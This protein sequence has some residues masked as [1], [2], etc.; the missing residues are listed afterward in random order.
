M[1]TGIKMQLT[2]APQ[3]A[4]FPSIVSA[5]QKERLAR[6]LPAANGSDALAF[7]FYLWNCSLCESFHFPLHFSEVVCRNALHQAL[8]KR[9]G[10]SW[11]SEPTFIG[12][13]DRR[14]SEDLTEAVSVERSQHGSKMTAHHIVS[15][16]T[17]GFWEHLATKRFERYLWAKGVQEV[18]PC[19]PKGTTLA[20]VHS[21]IESVRRWRN[22]IAHHRAIFDKGPM[23]K[24]QDAICLIKWACVDTGGWVASSSK[25][26]VAI[27]LKPK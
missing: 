6:Y 17:F 13:L 19:A 14:F 26:P 3:P 18:F 20:E 7:Q 1:P 4:M 15:T 25:V 8:V 9:A 2:N 16:L 24:Y 27:S 23:R 22:R 5:I 10:A 12:I 11:Y 21:L